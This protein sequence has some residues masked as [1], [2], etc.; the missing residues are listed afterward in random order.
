MSPRTC[1]GDLMEIGLSR[2]E[3][4]KMR[5]P[6]PQWTGVFLRRGEGHGEDTPEQETAMWGQGRAEMGERWRPAI[7]RSQWCKEGFSRKNCRGV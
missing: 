1:E 3:L 7:A 5:S 6:H 4:T 2:R